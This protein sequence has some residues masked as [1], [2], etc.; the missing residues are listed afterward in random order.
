MF[1]S[2]DSQYDYN[3]NKKEYIEVPY[4]IKTVVELKEDEN[5]LAKICH[6]RIVV[7]DYKQIIY[8]GLTSNVYNNSLEPEYEI[9]SEELINNWTKTK[10]I[11][12]EKIDESDK[13]IIPIPG[14]SE[15]KKIKRLF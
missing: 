7:E 11:I 1:N 12:I 5:V 4:S 2:R 6:Y 10:K 14:L 13:F 9:T 8:V 3:P 15:Y